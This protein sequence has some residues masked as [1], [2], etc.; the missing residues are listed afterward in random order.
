MT[1]Q[2]GF[3]KVISV[4]AAA[5]EVFKDDIRAAAVKFGE[6]LGSVESDINSL[7][8]TEAVAYVSYLKAAIGEAVGEIEKGMDS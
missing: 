7:T 8:S 3:A 4:S 5:V 6:S 2:T 1:E